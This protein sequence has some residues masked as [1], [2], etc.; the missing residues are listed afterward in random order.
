MS[1]TPQQAAGFKAANTRKNKKLD[2]QVA[3]GELTVQ[4]AAGHKSAAK[5][6]LN[7]VL[8]TA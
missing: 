2:E 3:S 8:E 4:Q 7:K 5:K 1:I 6:R